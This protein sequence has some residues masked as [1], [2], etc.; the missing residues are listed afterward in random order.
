MSGPYRHT[1]AETTISERSE[2]LQNLSTE[3]AGTTATAGGPIERM[4]LIR[5]DGRYHAE[6]VTR[7]RE[8]LEAGESVRLVGWVERLVAMEASAYA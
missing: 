8:R 3:A 6:P 4:A 2:D 1:I 5:L 7:V